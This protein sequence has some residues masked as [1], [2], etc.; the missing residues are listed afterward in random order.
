MANLRVR[1]IDESD[2]DTVLAE[3]FSF[4]GKIEFDEPLLVKG[5]V[6]GE[7]KTDSDLFVAESARVEA[8]I[9]ARRVSVKGAVTGDVNAI[10]RI[11]LFAGA[12]LHGNIETPD[13]IIQSGCRFSGQC[14]MPQIAVGGNT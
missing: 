2:L 1:T 8:D 9:R 10:E 3:D 7:L 6:A 4:E 12:V 14:S 5:R 13:L 11:E